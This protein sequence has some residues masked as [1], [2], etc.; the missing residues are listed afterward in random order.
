M[1]YTLSELNLRM[2][3]ELSKLNFSY[4]RVDTQ[5]SA[6]S[7]SVVVLVAADYRKGNDVRKKI[8]SAQAFMASIANA[9]AD[10][11][12]YRARRV[13][14]QRAARRRERVS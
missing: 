12:A 11:A 10:D 3:Y 4:R 1:T 13:G 14:R 9:L 5:L 7:F 6:S 8:G 2:T